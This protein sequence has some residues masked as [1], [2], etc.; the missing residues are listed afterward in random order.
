MH[1]KILIF[2][3][4][5][6]GKSTLARAL[7][8]TENLA[9]L[10]LD[11]YAWLD[12]MPPQRAAL[13]DSFAKVQEFLDKN[14]A[15]VIEGCYTDLLE[16][17][18]SKANEIIFLNLPIESCIEN[19]KNRPWEAHKYASK[20][21]QDENLSMLLDWIAQYSQRDDVFSHAA[22]LSF[23]AAFSGK[24]TMLTRNTEINC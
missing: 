6:S 19:A 2:G 20:Q 18:S 23:Y 12:T 15:W 4:S 16:L 5:G 8:K 17:L 3:N 22:H 7:A 1:K 13:K 21:K 14:Q 24:K 11:N 10:D 9:H